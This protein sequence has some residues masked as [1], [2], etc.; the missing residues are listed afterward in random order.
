[1][2]AEEA[3]LSPTV[4]GILVAAVVL[5]LI[6]VFLVC[7]CCC[8][9]CWCCRNLRRHYQVSLESCDGCCCTIQIASKRRVSCDRPVL[10]ERKPSSLP[11]NFH[12]FITAI[13][14][15]SFEKQRLTRY[16][17]AVVVLLSEKDL[18]NICGMKFIPSYEGQPILDKHHPS[19]PKSAINYIAARPSS[20]GCH[21][22]EEIFGKYSSIN[23]PF[24]QLW[25]AYLKRNRS[26]P[27]CVLLYSW[28]LPCSRCT[29]V[30]I[31]SLNDSMYRC[32][33]VIV[34]HTI[35]W[36]SESEEEHRENEKKLKKENIAV[37]Q[38]PYPEYLSPA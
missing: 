29:D 22:E 12:N 10:Q 17:F 34:A 2:A 30:I 19:M 14:I 23:S 32:T 5:A 31:R 33:S 11:N 15:P 9:Y 6:I 35:Y 8:C 3:G 25:T 28:Q 20:D 38:V 13:I 7:C 4:L 36:R 27:K 24:S 1:M 21:S 18:N 37:V 26:T 16:Q